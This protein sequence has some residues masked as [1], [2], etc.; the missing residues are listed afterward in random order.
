M[1][2]KWAGR[3]EKTATGGKRGERVE[4]SPVT[5]QR[6]RGAEIAC[7]AVVTGSPQASALASEQTVGKGILGPSRVTGPAVQSPA[8]S[9]FALIPKRDWDQLVSDAPVISSQAPTL[10]G[11]CLPK[12]PLCSWPSS[13]PGPG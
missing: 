4:K 5:R 9:P 2:G 8:P 11:W 12:L 10:Q 6:G 3:G 1:R 13:Y 7:V